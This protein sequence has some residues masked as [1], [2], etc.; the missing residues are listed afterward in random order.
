MGNG[1]QEMVRV[2]GEVIGIVKDRNEGKLVR[3]KG[4]A[5]LENGKLNLFN[6]SQM[7]LQGWVMQGTSEQIVICKGKM[8]LEFHIKIPTTKG[9]LYGIKIFNQNEFCGVAGEMT[10]TKINVM[11]AHKKLGHIGMQAVKA[12]SVKLGWELTGNQQVCEACAE[13]E[14]RQKDIIA[15]VV[16]F[17]NSSN[18]TNG[19]VYSDISS[20]KN[21]E[22][23]G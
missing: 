23:R 17:A 7:L 4:S 19:R 18:K 3:I 12:A 20:I 5:Y 16:N 14:A 13:G 6:K 15:R 1:S 9:V 2:S 8:V 10:K 22:F 21:N 11:K